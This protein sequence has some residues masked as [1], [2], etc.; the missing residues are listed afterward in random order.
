MIH[1]VKSFSVDSETDV[2]LEFPCFLCD[3]KKWTQ[4]NNNN[5][6]KKKNNESVSLT[7]LLWSLK[8]MMD[9]SVLEIPKT[10]HV[11]VQ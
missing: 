6:N 4:L 7:R 9:S 1:T 5:N 2:F 11:V 8:E 10:L 3:P